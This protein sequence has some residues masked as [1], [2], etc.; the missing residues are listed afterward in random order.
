MYTTRPSYDDVLV[1]DVFV[2]AVLSVCLS[3]RA[4]PFHRRVDIVTGVRTEHSEASFAPYRRQNASY[5]G[6]LDVRWCAV[7]T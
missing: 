1:L 7:S 4:L 3:R 2:V 5:F 6:F